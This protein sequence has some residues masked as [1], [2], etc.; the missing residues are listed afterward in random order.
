MTS[1]LF[2]VFDLIQIS[3]CDTT[4]DEKIKS[5]PFRNAI[6]QFVSFEHNYYVFYFQTLTINFTVNFNSTY[7]KACK[8]QGKKGMLEPKGISNLK[9]RCTFDDASD[10]PS[11]SGKI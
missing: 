3:A 9:W 11:T 2:P 1:D 4:D 5:F 7:I 6:I 10:V 8:V